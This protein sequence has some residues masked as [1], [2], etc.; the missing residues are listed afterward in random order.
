MILR[1]ITFALG[2]LFAVAIALRLGQR[3]MAQTSDPL[4][5][6][7]FDINL[8][9]AAHRLDAVQRVT[10]PNTY[11]RSIGEV[12]FNVPAV[13]TSG[14][15]DLHGVEVGGQAAVYDFQGTTLAV[16]LPAPLQPDQTTSLTLRFTV[17]VPSLADAQSFAS[18]NLAYTGDAMN[19]G[20][21]YPLL[22]PYQSGWVTVPWYPIGDPF[23]SESA[24]YTATITADLGVTVVSGGALTRHGN[25]WH[26][27][28]PRARTFGMLASS[29]YREATIKMGRVTY[30]LYTLPEHAH[31]ADAGLE[32]MVRA[33]T[34]F[35]TLYGPYPY[36]TLRVAEVSGPWSMEFSGFC[37]LGATDIGDYN[38]TPRNRLTRIMAHEVSHQWWYGVVGDNQVREPWLDE[39]L[40]RFN[41]LRYYE[42]YSPQDAQWWWNTVIGTLRGALPLNSAVG[43]FADHGT[44]LVSIYNQGAVFLDDL[45]STI[46]QPAFDA[47]LQD[48]Y[49]RGSFRL[50]TTQDFFDTLEYHSE[51]NVQALIRRYFR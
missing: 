28:L 3:T 11:G 4:P 16:K 49:R 6:Y 30:S 7:T 44:Y 24:D 33:L 50:I 13:H 36:S 39:G 37:A 8:G 25:V 38:G 26:Y 35:S 20:Y 48:L 32:T 12:L 14:V 51:V 47:F 46:G 45:R 15:F 21:W 43:D 5:H 10:L 41:E 31:L 22:A 9:Y 29:R 23:A 40:A 42:A 17:N 1:R 19:I 2:V 27:D 18:A 34:L